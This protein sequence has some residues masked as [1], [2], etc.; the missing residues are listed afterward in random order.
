M[1]D[2]SLK[3]F[4]DRVQEELKRKEEARREVHENM[5]KSIRLSKQAILFSHQGR[6]DDARW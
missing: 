4:L 6:I 3:S 5:R 2:L 1:R